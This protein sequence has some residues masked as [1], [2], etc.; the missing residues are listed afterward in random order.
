MRCFAVD[1]FECRGAL[2][3]QP[4]IKCETLLLHIIEMTSCSIRI[5]DQVPAV[6]GNGRW[7]QAEQVILQELITESLLTGAMRSWDEPIGIRNILGMDNMDRGHVDDA[8]TCQHMMGCVE[9]LKALMNR[10]LHNGG[11]RVDGRVDC[12]DTLGIPATTDAIRSF[13]RVP[14]VRMSFLIEAPEPELTRAERRRQ[15]R[16]E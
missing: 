8:S 9:H 13:A 5:E 3:V 7:Y 6:S 14:A 11:R 16:H 15:W 4:R 1:A 10:N 2:S 12:A